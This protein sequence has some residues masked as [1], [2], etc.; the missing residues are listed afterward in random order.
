[1]SQGMR[2]ERSIT[3]VVPLV[4]AHDKFVPELIGQLSSEHNVIASVIL[5]RSSARKRNLR[6]LQ[7]VI[8]RLQID[9]GLEIQVLAT[10]QQQLAGQ[11]RNRGW[12]HV[13][14]PFTAFLDADDEYAT[15]RLSRLLEVAE[16][17][18]SDLVLHDFLVKESEA[19]VLQMTSWVSD[20]LV[21]T[22]DL[23]QATFSQGRNRSS[24]GLFPG[25]TNIVVPPNRTQHTDIHHGHVL[26]RTDLRRAFRY[27][28]LYPGEDGQF[29]RDIL[30][31]GRIVTYVPSRLSA[32][33]PGLSA[34]KDAGSWLRIRRKMEKLNRRLQVHRS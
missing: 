8:P 3:V 11:N 12:S 24:E 22:E 1:M 16:S 5:A 33:R 32:Y 7:L 28:N 25:D 2:S 15:D 9:H 13:R 6:N 31:A 14:T 4:P 23:Y 30:W 20:D 26:V 34:E 10:R 19:D 21:R 27:S 18:A 17:E 29:C